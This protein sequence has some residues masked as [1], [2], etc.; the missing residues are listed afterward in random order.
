MANLNQTDDAPQALSQ[1]SRAHNSTPSMSMEHPTLMQHVNQ[2]RRLHGCCAEEDSVVYDKV[3]SMIFPGNALRRLLVQHANIIPTSRFP[4]LTELRFRDLSLDLRFESLLWHCLTGCSLLQVLE[5]TDIRISVRGSESTCAPLV[6]LVPCKALPVSGYVRIKLSSLRSLS[7]IQNPSRS[8]E[9]VL[10]HTEIESVAPIHVTR[11]MRWFGDYAHIPSDCHLKLQVARALDSNDLEYFRQLFGNNAGLI[12]VAIIECGEW[13]GASRVLKVILQTTGKA[14]VIFEI[15]DTFTPTPVLFRSEATEIHTHPLRSKFLGKELQTIK[16]LYIGP[17]A[18]RTA[19]LLSSESYPE[20]EVLAI[21]P[22]YTAPS[23]PS[24]SQCTVR[25]ALNAVLLPVPDQT[26]SIAFP[27]LSTLIIDYTST[28]RPG[29][30]PLM[31]SDTPRQFLQTIKALASVREPLGHPIARVYILVFVPFA[32]E[33]SLGVPSNARNVDSQTAG[34]LSR[35]LLEYDATSATLL[36][37]IDD[38]TSNEINEK[39]WGGYVPY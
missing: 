34:Q 20:L 31:V 1:T 37:A 11:L 27:A 16:R 15:R 32:G 36:R 12:H 13:R 35:L 39:L 30:H 33:S 22:W 17:D 6:D 5:L 8:S 7:F 3:C 23:D 25:D 21:S 10:R 29:V 2:H 9:S 38:G 19:L 18:I 14:Q 4:A 28:P 26:L 24:S